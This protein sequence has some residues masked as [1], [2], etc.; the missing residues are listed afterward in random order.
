MSR[1]YREPV[2]V[3]GYKSKTKKW[4]KRDANKRVRSALD[5]PNGKGYRK[6]TNPWDICDY[7][8]RWSPYSYYYF[9]NGEMREIKPSP[10]WK[11]R[12]K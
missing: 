4:R 5:V 2:F 6:I 9:Y 3:E 7:K 11:A 10:E 1:S 8:I 12:R